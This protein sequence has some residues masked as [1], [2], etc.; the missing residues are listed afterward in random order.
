MKE[1]QHILA[2]ME[3]K[4]A[5][6]ALTPE[7]KK[8]MAHIDAEAGVEFITSLLGEPGGDKVSSMVH[9]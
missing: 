6:K 9:L 3:P 1:L 7:I 5:L 2:S 8:I 4:E